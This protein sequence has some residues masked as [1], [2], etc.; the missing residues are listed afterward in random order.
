MFELPSVR[1]TS[2]PFFASTK[3]Q[4]PDLPAPS[5]IILLNYSKFIC[6]NIYLVK[7]YSDGQ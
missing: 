4:N 6:S 3:P 1:V 2:K 7:I 5:S